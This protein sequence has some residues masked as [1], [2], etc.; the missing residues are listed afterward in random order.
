M[1]AIIIFAT[2]ILVLCAISYSRVGLKDK[3]ATSTTRKGK[4]VFRRRQLAREYRDSNK[5]PEMVKTESVIMLPSETFFS[6]AGV[7]SAIAA[8]ALVGEYVKDMLVWLHNTVRDP[9]DFAYAEPILAAVIALTAYATAK[10]ATAH[11]AM[12]HARMIAERRIEKRRTVC[13]DCESGVVEMIEQAGA[14]TISWFTGAN[15]RREK[16]EDVASAD[17]AD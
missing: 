12:S 4:Y 5:Q 15:E 9:F 2:T 11:V 14:M 6:M 7:L 10:A 1:R 3:T 17:I 16:A 8:E 13:F